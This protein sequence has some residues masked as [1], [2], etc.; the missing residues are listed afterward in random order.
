MI[1]QPPSQPPAPPAGQEPPVTSSEKLLAGGREL[2]IEH[3]TERYRLRLTSTNK[4][5]LV[6]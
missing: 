1:D 5:I 6:K 3:G 4:L 2:I